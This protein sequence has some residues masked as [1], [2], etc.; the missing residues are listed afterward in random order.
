MLTPPGVGG[1][2]RARRRGHSRHRGRKILVLLVLLTA[3]AVVAGWLWNQHD[4]TTVAEVQRPT[5]PPTQAAPTT[6]AARSVHLNVYNATKRRGLAT[7]IAVLIGPES[8]VP[9]GPRANSSFGREQAQ[10][11][12]QA[13][14]RVAA[15]I[16]E[17]YA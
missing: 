7:E 16:M 1:R 17:P 11:F 5:C 6:V 12:D 8:D 15:A 14:E 4:G 10:R 2:P 3:A 13:S 9:A